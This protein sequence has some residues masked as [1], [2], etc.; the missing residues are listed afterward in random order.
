MNATD[1]VVIWNKGQLFWTGEDNSVCDQNGL[2]A[3]ENQT[4]GS[5]PMD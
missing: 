1:R 2:P 4:A 3:M 5:F